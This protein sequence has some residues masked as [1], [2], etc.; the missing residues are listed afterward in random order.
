M[1]KEADYSRVTS[2]G[3]ND[4][5]RV[6]KGGASRNITKDNFVADINQLLIDAGFLT[7][8]NLPPSVSST[9]FIQT[10][11]VSHSLLLTDDLI[12]M[13]ATGSSL[14]VD[15]PFAASAY[16]AAEYKGQRFTIK[17]IDSSNV[18]TVTIN[19]A[20]ADLIDGETSVILETDSRPFVTIISDG[21]NWWLI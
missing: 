18:N 3:N 4:T 20:G 7:D 13:D 9:R 16:D 5:I 8:S 19:P 1:A 10:F 15:L 6:I 21:G 14:V 12:L 17:K 11:G 2:I